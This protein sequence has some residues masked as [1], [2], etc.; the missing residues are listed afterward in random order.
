MAPGSIW[1]HMAPYGSIA[2]PRHCNSTEPKAQGTRAHGETQCQGELRAGEGNELEKFC[3]ISVDYR[4]VDLFLYR[5]Q[6]STD[7]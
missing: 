6:K 4:S 1:L 7:L 2:S 5:L 3:W